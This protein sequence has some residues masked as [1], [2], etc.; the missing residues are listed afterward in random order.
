MRS[1][2]HS[3]SVE[4]L[5]AAFVDRLSR[6]VEHAIDARTR[7]LAAEWMDVALTPTAASQELTVSPAEAPRTHALSAA[8]EGQSYAEAATVEATE[9]P[10]ATA[11]ARPKRVGRRAKTSAAAAGAP[12]RSIGSSSTVLAPA[13][14]SPEEERRDAEFARL[15]ALLKPTGQ[16]DASRTGETLS[17]QPRT[18]AVAP[19]SDPLRLLE[20]E[21]R[22]Q[23]HGLTQLPPASCTARIAAWAGRVRSYEEATGNRVAADLLLDKLR[24]LARAMDAGRIEALNGSWRTSDWGA[25]IRT[26]EGLADAR[27][28]R[29]QA[30]G[31]STADRTGEPDYR[32]V[33]SQPS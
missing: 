25:Y 11:H 13:V 15:R 8:D 27:P 24:A 3:K 33:W 22:L 18:S 19:P 9:P 21:V 26:N 31:D 28:A 14:P 5:T 30:P 12:H 23:A 16:E 29:P 6:A 10:P 4:S 17:A 2:Q 1:R 20:D 32:E 7:I